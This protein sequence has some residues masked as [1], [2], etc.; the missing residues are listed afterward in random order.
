MSKDE[1][2]ESEIKQH[3]KDEIMQLYDSLDERRQRL[4]LVHIRALAGKN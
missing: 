4:V 3:R 2:T 1:K